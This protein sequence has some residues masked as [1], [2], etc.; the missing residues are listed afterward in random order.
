MITRVEVVNDALTTDKTLT[1]KLGDPR[2]S[3]FA[4]AS[5]TGLDP[6]QASINTIEIA[7][8]D[9]ASFSSARISSRNI[10]LTMLVMDEWPS[11]RLI[12]SREYDEYGSAVEYNRKV[13]YHYFPLK[14][15]VTI[16]FILSV[17]GK[18]KANNAFEIDGYVENVSVGMFSA[19]QSAQ[20]SIMCPFPYFRD[21]ANSL[22]VSGTFNTSRDNFE[23]P[24]TGE[25]DDEGNPEL[26]PFYE[27]DIQ[28]GLIE[29]NPRATIKYIGTMPTGYVYDLLAN[30]D[31]G[32]I[33][34][35]DLD[36]GKEFKIL[37]EVV[38]KLTGAP[39]QAGDRIVIDSR[40][41]KKRITLT[42]IGRDYNILNSLD[43]KSSWLTLVP[44]DNVVRFDA[45]NDADSVSV[46]IRSDILY[47]G[48]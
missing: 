6:G 35:T 23:F 4:L 11:K 42:R 43:K 20:V 37:T 19:S 12:K 38:N 34:I 24:F 27:E 47:G 3:G 10:V 33:V 40:T 46:N 8:A 48:I 14:G 17:V 31:P 44:G 21:A 26:L 15:K 1:M 18:G 30:S 5:I 28:F 32:D 7:G 29:A 16:R 36:N 9:G 22:E 41:G 2:Y 45:T 39:I 13:L 25:Y